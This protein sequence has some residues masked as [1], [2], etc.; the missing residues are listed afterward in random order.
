[1]A[2]AL[3]LF[4][5][6]ILLI[7]TRFWN[8]DRTARFIWDESSDLVSM[9]QIWEEKNIT[10]V[11]PI[12]EDGNKVFGSLTYYMLLPFAV[13]GGFGAVSTAFG[14]AF[15]G[16]L[17]SILLYLYLVRV[18]KR[19]AVLSF[20]VSIS[21]LPLLESGRWAWNPNLIPFWV[22][23]TLW[24][25]SFKKPIYIFLAGIALG[26]SFHHHYL[27]VFMIIL[28]SALY[29]WAGFQKHKTSNGLYFV[30]GILLSL[31]PFVI[32]DLTHPLGLFISRIL[33][34][35]YLGS[36]E[37]TFINL[38]LNTYFQMINYF[39]P[40]RIG[41]LL[42]TFLVPVL[43]I[44]DIFSNSRNKIMYALVSTGYIIWLTTVEVVYNHYFLPI[45]IVFIVWLFM[46]RKGFSKF[47]AN[48]MILLVIASSLLALPN[49][50][51]N[52][53][54][55]SDIKSIESIT[56]TIENATTEKELKNVNIVV[57]GSDDTNIY[58]RRY[59]DLLLIRKKIDILSKDEIYI[60]D[61]LFV[62]TTSSENELRKDAASE[63][64]NFRDGPI[65]GIWEI[66]G[67]DWKVYLFNRK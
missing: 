12:S 50:L 10:L 32:F 14:A 33:Y 20:L 56:S 18:L 55:E 16:T 57:L 38:F 17:T 35:N 4:F 11:G 49:T 52:V 1:M 13:I 5:A 44:K 31:S 66:K 63:L 54:W 25:I 39:V 41:A 62:I 3:I 8:L 2:K 64:N 19:N 28:F 59:R 22:I 58:G 46:K 37:N 26:L 29:L 67:S 24:L 6:L 65:R 15:W 36:T 34:F 42:V 30:V 51:T 27:S 21:W 48:T 40:L 47:I 45:A 9:H 43:F 23:T 7:F 61:N 60:T 53:S